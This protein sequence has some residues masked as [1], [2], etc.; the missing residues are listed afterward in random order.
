MYQKISLELETIKFYKRKAEEFQFL[1]QIDF[2][3][4]TKTRALET[5]N[6][7]R[8]SQISIFTKKELIL[9]LKFDNEHL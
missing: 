2:Q 8:L 4:Q 1:V 6:F 3:K 7:N 5:I 9:N